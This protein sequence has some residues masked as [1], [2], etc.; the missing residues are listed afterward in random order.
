MKPR[1]IQCSRRPVLARFH[2]KPFRFNALR[3]RQ[4]Q[5]SFDRI[6]ADCLIRVDYS[7]TGNW[8]D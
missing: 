3:R 7:L 5:V 2:D 1:P 4:D 6:L 8:P